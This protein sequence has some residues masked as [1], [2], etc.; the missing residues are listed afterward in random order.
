MDDERVGAVSLGVE[1]DNVVATLE[2]G[3]GVACVELFE[4]D[5]DALASNVDATNETDNF[6]LVG[7]F[8][9]E[10]LHL[11]VELGQTRHELVTTAA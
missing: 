5:L 10:L 1:V 4:T 9:L 6:A 8:L 3:D 11:V 2:S 7:G